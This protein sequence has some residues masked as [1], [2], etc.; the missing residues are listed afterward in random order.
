MAPDDR[1]RMFD[2]AL[3]RHLRSGSGS[4]MAAN[5]GTASGAVSSS[6]L[7]PEM[8]A[9][10]HE[11][12]LLPEEMNSAKEHIVGCA[13]C[14]AILAQLELTDFIPLAAAKEEPRAVA[15][16]PATR[17]KALRRIRLRGP[18]WAWLVPAGAL[19]AGLL[20]W[21][22]LHETQPLH[23]PASNEV[24]IAR[25]EKP[26][27]PLPTLNKQSVP[28]LTAPKG[29][30]LDENSRTRETASGASGGI[31][32]APPKAIASPQENLKLPAKADAGAR[33]AGLP[34]SAGKESEFR[35][36]KDAERD[37]S[38]ALITGQNQPA[39]E[40]K[41]AVVGG[42][43]QDQTTLQNQGALQSQ[44][45]LQNQ[46]VNIVAQNQ[47]LSPKVPGPSPLGQ[48]SQAEVAKKQKSVS[49]PSRSNAAAA[50]PA[51]PP[52]AATAFA[53]NVSLDAR[54]L[55]NQHL[56]VVPGS[57]VRWLAGGAGLIEFSADN[58]ASWSVQ[59]SGVTVDLLTGSAPSGKICWMV[60]RAGVIVLTTDGG[61][62]WLTVT[63]PLKEDL[64]GI[65]ASD[66]LHATVW[67]LLKTKFFETSDG[68]LIWKPVP[69]P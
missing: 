6:C 42:V 52:P 69:A 32:G 51:P 30:V 27:E 10:Y 43:P 40:V 55:P 60:G 26:A 68:G 12:S 1:D 53:D 28:A 48:M 46:N 56:I 61:A 39:S 31:A 22:G 47:A 16:Q 29:A 62:H 11:R 45:T 58:G 3:S 54:A 17:E 18:R 34:A 63:P 21:I 67:N 9:A 41:G 36:D 44:A 37:S 38:V 66:A 19:A 50:A 15:A 64:G 2:K 57:A 14:Q 4:P 5:L 65:R 23:S 20:V 13:H 35:K 8:L 33:V 59:S 49:A 25:A 24:K 7:D